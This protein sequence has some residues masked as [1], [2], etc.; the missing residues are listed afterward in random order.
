[1]ADIRGIE[2]ASEI[3]SLEDTSAR[4]TATAASQAATQAGQTATQA[5]QTA[6]AASQTASAASQTATQ[7]DGKADANA[8]AISELQNDV[9]T[10]D[11][12]TVKKSDVTSS[13]AEGNTNPISSG[14]IF[15]KLG[16]FSSKALQ[17]GVPFNMNPYGVANIEGFLQNQGALKATLLASAPGAFNLIYDTASIATSGITVSGTGWNPILTFDGGLIAYGLNIS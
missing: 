12:T 4:N 16:H 2:L 5:S 1:M 8:T 7:A 3:Y 10:L 15:S 11:D 13:V 6:S 14:G 9:E 17:S